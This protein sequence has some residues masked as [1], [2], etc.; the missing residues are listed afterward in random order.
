MNAL[1][2][3]RQ[4][5]RAAV[6]ALYEGRCTVTEYRPFTKPNKATGHHEVDVLSGRPCRLSFGAIPAAEQTG[7]GASVQQTVKLFIAPDVIIK[8][9]SRITVTQNG[10]TTDYC[11]TGEPAV[12]S[13]HQE[14]TLELWK[15]WT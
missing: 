14:I 7:A 15:G 3:A 11:R 9:G 4:A 13:T 6:E 2:K 5:H 10:V 1:K 12:Y 8:P